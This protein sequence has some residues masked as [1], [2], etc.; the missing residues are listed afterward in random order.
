MDHWQ[1]KAS[2][3]NTLKWETLL[4]GGYLTLLPMR[5]N[6]KYK[7]QKNN[8]LRVQNEVTLQTWTRNCWTTRLNYV[9]FLVYLRVKKL[10]AWWFSTTADPYQGGLGSGSLTPSE[11]TNVGIVKH[12]FPMKLWSQPWL[13]DSK[14]SSLVNVAVFSCFKLYFSRVFL[15]L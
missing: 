15:T 13:F 14:I 9:K 3:M 10:V 7:I 12:E 5:K 8:K 4:R 2:S 1:F 11:N 6:K